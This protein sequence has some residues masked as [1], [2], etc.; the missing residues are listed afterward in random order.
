MKQSSILSFSR[1]RSV[2]ARRDRVSLPLRA[3]LLAALLVL[4]SASAASAF[5]VSPLARPVY[6][7]PS[8][9]PALMELRAAWGKY[10]DLRSWNG[11][12]PCSRWW[13]VSCWT[14]G[15]VRR[16]DVSSKGIQGT[17]PAVLGNLTSLEELI[18]TTNWIHGDIPDSFSK[19]VNLKN[20][21]LFKNYL[22]GTI[23]ASMGNMRSLY[24][25]HLNINYL[26]GGIPDTF[27]QLTKMRK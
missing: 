24:Q 3:L 5:K 7:A 17:L 25:L 26:T 8:Q 9:L 2:S 19:L 27:S 21:Q 10:M 18:A 1:P 15:L 6:V 16:M 20:L 12:N 4:L 14:N 13:L 22:N 23:P 11:S